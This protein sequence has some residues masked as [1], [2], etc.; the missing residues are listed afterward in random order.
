MK[1]FSVLRLSLMS[2]FMFLA[3]AG[4]LPANA[5]PVFV[6][7]FLAL[8][9]AD[10]AA[11]D[12]KRRE[13][14][15]AGKQKA[16]TATPAQKAAAHLRQAAGDLRTA[17]GQLDKSPS[18][19][20]AELSGKYGLP[21]TTPVSKDKKLLPLASGDWSVIV[22][23]QEGLSADAAVQQERLALRAA[24]NPGPSPQAQAALSADLLGYLEEHAEEYGAPGMRWFMSPE[25]LA[26]VKKLT[27]PSGLP[28]YKARIR[29]ARWQYDGTLLKYPVVTGDS[30]GAPELRRD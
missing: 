13:E 28:L 8:T 23:T 6:L 19:Q 2:L 18:Q 22:A 25:W 12:R 1:L 9:F 24:R 27:L 16:V 29:T 21:V 17:A 15:R 20:L 4:L 30:Y 26:E 11:R 7:V 14:I 5:L 3:V 10:S